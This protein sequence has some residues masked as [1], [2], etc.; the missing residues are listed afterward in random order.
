MEIID[1]LDEIS[2]VSDTSREELQKITA[3]KAYLKGDHLLKLWHVSRHLHYIVSGS[4]RIYYMRE[5][6]DI[7][8]YFAMDGQFIGG[9]ESLFTGE[10]SHKAIELTEDSVVQSFLYSDFEDLCHKH[11]DVERL[12]R[13]LATFAFL[14]AQKLVESTRFLSAAERYEELKERHPGISNHIPLRHLASYLN[15]SPVSLS[16]IRSGEQ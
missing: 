11:H 13:K 9:L 2:P 14:D 15:I 1:A 12:G 7:S 10:P 5:G 6:R 3:Q 4:A 8:D 16:R